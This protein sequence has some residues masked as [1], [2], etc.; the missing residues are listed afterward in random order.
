MSFSFVI[1][2][3]IIVKPHRCCH[4][5]IRVPLD[6]RSQNNTTLLNLTL[7]IIYF[8]VYF[9]SPV[10]FLCVG[11]KYYE[12]P[13][14]RPDVSA[15]VSSSRSLENR[16]DNSVRLYGIQGRLII[17]FIPHN[18]MNLC[19]TVKYLF[20]AKYY[21]RIIQNMHICTLLIFVYHDFVLKLF[22]SCYQSASIAIVLN[23]FS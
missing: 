18:L 4:K 13:C 8:I 16:T 6:V 14:A 11:G 23:F 9:V 10:V 2:I 22:I 21:E 20:V 1:S 5:L 17:I 19:M 3:P 7:S 15:H 12:L